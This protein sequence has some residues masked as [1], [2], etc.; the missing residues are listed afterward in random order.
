MSVVSIRNAPT[1]GRFVAERTTLT[2]ALAR[3]PPDPSV[4]FAV[5]KIVRSSTSRSMVNPKVS[6]LNSS[7]LS[8]VT[9]TSGRPKIITSSHRLAASRM[10]SCCAAVR[11]LSGK[12]TS[13]S[14]SS[15][16][17]SG[18][19]EL[20][21]PPPDPPPEPP[22]EPPPDPPPLGL[23][24]PPPGPGGVSPCQPGFVI[25]WPGSVVTDRPSAETVAV[26][27]ITNRPVV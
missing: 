7:N 24:P 2:P 15:G 16:G 21:E 4:P 23:S 5:T 6:I 12:I 27:S 10:M 13:M 20:P 3:L 14:Y 22:P 19:D 11:L 8:S 17:M 26:P 1:A 9:V 18:S 25:P